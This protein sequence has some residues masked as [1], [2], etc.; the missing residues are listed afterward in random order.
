MAPVDQVELLHLVA[1]MS[2]RQTAQFFT[3]YNAVQRNRIL[4]LMVSIVFG[5]L[6]IDRFLI[7]DT[8]IGLVKLLT[9]GGLGILW[10]I[11]IFIILGRVDNYNRLKA[12]EIARTLRRS[13]PGS[14]MDPY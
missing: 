8:G 12:E 1:G 5:A 7:G 6:G 14:L 11:D 9:A 13:G 2:D 3:Q 10:F 4:V